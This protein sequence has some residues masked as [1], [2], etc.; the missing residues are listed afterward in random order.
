MAVVN[1]QTAGYV[2][3]G[4]WRSGRSKETPGE[5][6]MAGIGKAGRRGTANRRLRQRGIRV[7]ITDAGSRGNGPPT[8]SGRGCLP[9]MV[10]AFA[11]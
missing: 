10:R 4:R 3:R 5:Q 9:T 8:P 2:V 7:L 1:E 6:Q 11:R